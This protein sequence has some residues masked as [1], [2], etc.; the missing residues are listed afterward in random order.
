MYV[1][2]KLS[3]STL[4]T[5]FGSKSKSSVLALSP[6]RSAAVKQ[7]RPPTI[8]TQFQKNVCELVTK[9]ETCMPHYIRC[10]KSNDKKASFTVNE[11]RVRHQTRFTYTR[12]KTLTSTFDNEILN[13][14]YRYLNLVETVRVRKA[15]F[16]NRQ[17]YERFLHRYIV[18]VMNLSVCR[19]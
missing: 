2:C 4:P 9:L 11:E 3:T 7:K 1:R 10:I 12:N 19:V 5:G 18:C 14:E 13:I 8:G 16:C 17:V 15:G 6:R